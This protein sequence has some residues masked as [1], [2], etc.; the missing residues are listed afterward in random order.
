MPPTHRQ[1]YCHSHH[2][3]SGSRQRGTGFS[4]L[5]APPSGL[6]G[7]DPCARALSPHT[8]SAATYRCKLL[9]HLSDAQGRGSAGDA[10]ARQAELRRLVLQEVA[11]CAGGR[12]SQQLAAEVA[13]LCVLGRSTRGRAS[14]SSYST[15]IQLGR[16]RRGPQPRQTHAC[17]L[18]PNRPNTQA[19]G[20]S[21]GGGGWSKP[22]H[23]NGGGGDDGAQG[24][25]HLVC[26]WR[27]DATGPR[28]RRAFI[29]GVKVGH[30]SA[31]G[32]QAR[33]R[34][35]SAAM[36][37]LG[38]PAA[39]CSSFAGLAHP[40]DGRARPLADT[41]NLHAMRFLCMQ[42]WLGP[43]SDGIL[44][45]LAAVWLV[46]QAVK[47]HW[48]ATAP[49]A[50]AVAS[51]AQLRADAVASSAQLQA[52]VAAVSAQLRA[53]IAAASAQLRADMA[54]LEDRLEAKF[55]RLQL[56]MVPSTATRAHRC[57]WRCRGPAGWAASKPAPGTHGAE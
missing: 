10:P 8:H 21:G 48:D 45:K 19:G 46:L 25:F 12:P 18:A 9:R 3:G 54:A 43:Y 37:A 2:P 1:M 15:H 53:E 49:R 31:K 52:E 55:D 22:P 56:S 11:A 14:S 38:W 23:A 36:R 4:G 27:R 47:I 35:G 20:D 17:Q 16:S 26:S 24:P 39:V 6:C 40:A 44:T 34:A 7:Y 30:T 51:S 50:N 5:G 42:A 33:G 32:S 57:A 28:R 29:T 41:H 13:A